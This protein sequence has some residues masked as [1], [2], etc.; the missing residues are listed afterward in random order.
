MKN[1]LLL[2]I[3]VLMVA[4]MCG[5]GIASAQ[6]AYACHTPEDSTLT[7]YYDSQ[8]STRTGITYNLN[9]G[10]NTPGWSEG[11]KGFGISQVVFDPS[12]AAARPTSTYKWFYCMANLRSFTG[13][14]YLNTEEVTTMVNMF[15]ICKSLTDLD[16]SSFNTTN[17]TTMFLMF[18]FCESLKTIDLS[19]F[20]TSNVT[21]MSHVF[22]SCKSLASLD[23]SSFN[24]SNVKNMEGMFDDCESLTSID[25]SGFNTEKLLYTNAMFSGCKSLASVDLTS[26]NTSNVEQTTSMFSGCESLKSLDLSS[27]NTSKIW[28]TRSMFSGC[29]NLETI[30]AGEGWSMESVTVSSDMFIGCTRLVGGQGTA[31]DE[32]HVDAA[33]AHIDG[34]PS[35]P[36]YFTEKDDIQ[37]GDVNAD[38][39]VNIADVNCIIAVILG[40]PDTYGGRADVNADGEVNIADINAVI[41]IIQSDTLVS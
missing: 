18:S 29:N 8:R 31:Y 14:D 1:P 38:G 13:L 23:L 33:Y 6:E 26:F 37:S 35:N 3:A 27:F 2:K 25:L 34:G 40:D 39:E 10:D 20:N 32:N 11:Y 19:S 7:F 30:Y 12:F 17:V 36:G 21:N 9:T 24:T 5:R 4:V 28:R 15:S 16:L 22:W 41:D